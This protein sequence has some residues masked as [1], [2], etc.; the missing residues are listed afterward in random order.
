[1]QASDSELTKP[2]AAS[3]LKSPPRL[4]GKIALV[5][6]AGQSPG[7][8]LGNGRASALLFARE[9]A[10]VIAADI[11]L[12][13]AQETVAMIEREGGTAESYKVDAASDAELDALIRHCMARHKRIDVLQ[14]NVGIS[15]AGGDAQVERL[16][17]SVF[18]HIMAV[19]LR[20]CVMA[21]KRVLPVM[22]AQQSGSIINIS[23]VAAY[24]KYPW[25][26]YKASKVAM[27]EFSKQIA[28]QYAA[29]GVRCN[30]ILPGLIDTPMAVDTRARAQGIAREA[31]AAQ[32][33]AQVPLKARMGGAM[34]VAYA[35]LFLASEEAR[36]ITGIAMPVDGGMLARIG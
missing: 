12:D 34:D 9:G 18:D 36:F 35:A 31:V 32:R 3:S 15:V 6:G 11:D 27:I 24:M 16:S 5:I 33:D 22:K 8:G 25:V 21:C 17:E 4:D 26:T 1:M 30:V 19:N 2:A 28:L 13:S 10:S 20:S 7:L 23:S 29:D 14:N